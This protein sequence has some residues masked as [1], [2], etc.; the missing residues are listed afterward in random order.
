MDLREGKSYCCYL[1]YKFELQGKE[2]EV[3]QCQPLSLE[4]Y[5]KKDK[6]IEET[7]KQIEGIG[8]TISSINLKCGN[9]D[10]KGEGE[11]GRETIPK[12][13]FI[14][15]SCLDCHGENI[16]KSNYIISSIFALALILF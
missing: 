6:M 2:K 4:E 1:S 16:I 14:T 3:S 5:S 9:G 12:K 15:K 7:K 8:G 10:G 11:D 13:K